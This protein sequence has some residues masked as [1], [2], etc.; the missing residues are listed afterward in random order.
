MANGTFVYGFDDE[1]KHAWGFPVDEARTLQAAI[2]EAFDAGRAVRA[3]FHVKLGGHLGARTLYLTPATPFH[4]AFIDAAQGSV[5]E[6]LLN[7]FRRAIGQGREIH[8]PVERMPE[9]DGEDEDAGQTGVSAEA[10]NVETSGG[11]SA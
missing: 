4:F 1:A 11:A 6:D 8:L 10:E 7:R 3:T 2:Y 9:E 5:D